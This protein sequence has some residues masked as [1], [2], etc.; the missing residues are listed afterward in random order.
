MASRNLM[1]TKRR[2]ILVE[3]PL[4]V[5]CLLPIISVA[6]S[7]GQTPGLQWYTVDGGGE[8]FSENGSLTLHG[9]IGQ[10]DAGIMSGGSLTLSGGFWFPLDFGDCDWDGTVSLFDE[11]AF[12]G[13]V[14]GPG[15]GP[16]PAGCDCFD[17]DGNGAIDLFDVA[18]MQESHTG[19]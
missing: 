4:F 5:A 12:V 3:L 19:P 15:G 11:A 14:T 17:L 1:A 7:S 9:T 13:C 2:R 8:M 18:V 16:V 10:P 6:G